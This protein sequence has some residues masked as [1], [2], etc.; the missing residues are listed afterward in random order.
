M[1]ANYSINMDIDFSMRYIALEILVLTYNLEKE[2]TFCTISF[3]FLLSFSL[4]ISGKININLLMDGYILQNIILIYVGA[5][6]IQ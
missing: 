2:Q 4:Y 1:W 5:K 6:P 3:A